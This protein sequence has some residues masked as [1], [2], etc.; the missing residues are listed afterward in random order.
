MFIQIYQTEPVTYISEIEQSP[1]SPPVFYPVPPYDDDTGL[2]KSGYFGYLESHKWLLAVYAEGRENLFSNTT[3]HILTANYIYNFPGYGIRDYEFDSNVGA[4]LNDEMENSPIASSSSVSEQQNFWLLRINDVQFRSDGSLIATTNYGIDWYSLD[5]NDLLLRPMPIDVTPSNYGAYALKVFLVDT[6]NSLLVKS[7]GPSI[8]AVA[9]IEVYQFNEDNLLARSIRVSGVPVQIFPENDKHC[10]VFTSNGLLNLIN[11][12]TGEVLSTLRAPTPVGTP[13]LFDKIGFVKY[14]YDRY[15]RRLIA[16]QLTADDQETG[17]S[18]LHAKG[19]YPVPIPVRIM[20]P[21]PV[22]PPRT[23]KKVPY[24][25]K[26]FGDVGEPIGGWQFYPIVDG[27]DTI[28]NSLSITDENGEAYI[29]AT[30]A[31][32]EEMTLSLEAETELA[33]L[34]SEATFT[35]GEASTETASTVLTILPAIGEGTGPGRLVHPTLGT[36]DYEKCPDEWSNMDGDAIIAPIWASSKT[37][38]GA[39]NTLFSGNIRDVVIEERWI[40]DLSVSLAMLRM[41]AAFWQNPPN[42]ADG[43]IEWYPNYIN[44]LGFKVIILALELNGQ[45]INFDY[46]ARQGYVSGDLV[47]RMRIAGRVA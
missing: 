14:C 7:K 17:A 23:G 38:D 9:E 31:T 43:Y 16:V 1:F 44:E 26:L 5:L 33:T 4:S 11:Y 18:T 19:W 10:Y 34:N 28:I 41:L 6:E 20:K 25:T 27:A 30:S 12:V 39:A 40:G 2:L 32:A 15:Y 46:M 8:P 22:I 35:I 3:V 45:G 24:L 29:L 21:I 37:L 47:L 42:P 36:Y 13:T